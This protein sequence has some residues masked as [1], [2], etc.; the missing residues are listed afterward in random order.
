MCRL[1]QAI[2]RL[3]MIDAYNDET[4]GEI[5]LHS[6]TPLG[7]FTHT[8]K[9]TPETKTKILQYLQGETDELIQDFIPELSAGDRELLIS[10]IP[11][12]TFNEI[13]K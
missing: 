7:K 4:P 2:K 3:I 5:T 13:M 10:G 9:C 8:I 6:S 11:E 12:E 1:W